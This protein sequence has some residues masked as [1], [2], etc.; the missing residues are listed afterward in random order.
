MKNK[1][2]VR[3]MCDSIEAVR[4]SCNF[5]V[6][7]WF[8]HIVVKMETLELKIANNF[9]DFQEKFEKLRIWCKFLRFVLQ[10]F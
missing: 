1:T 5:H 7:I 4:I 2:S 6:R 3:A 9:E 8:E 10:K